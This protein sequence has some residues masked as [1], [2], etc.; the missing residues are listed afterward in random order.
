[1]KKIIMYI[2]FHVAFQGFLQCIEVGKYV[3]VYIKLFSLKKCNR[4]HTQ[5]TAKA[6]NRFAAVENARTRRDERW[7]STAAAA[8]HIPI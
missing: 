8:K 3:Y 6:V 2:F 4:E 5:N 1:M 7:Y